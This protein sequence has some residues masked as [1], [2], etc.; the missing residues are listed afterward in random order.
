MANG[1]SQVTP[2]PFVS[3]LAQFAGPL[4]AG[5]SREFTC[6]IGTPMKAAVGTMTTNT[7][8]MSRGVEGELENVPTVIQPSPF[9]PSDDTML[10]H[11]EKIQTP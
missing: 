3:N 4:P 8:V 5:A 2:L 6:Q 11:N 10:M 9:D 1:S 7:A